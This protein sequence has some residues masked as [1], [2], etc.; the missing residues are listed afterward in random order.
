MK[1]ARRFNVARSRVLTDLP[2]AIIRG[3]STFVSLRQSESTLNLKRIVPC[4]RVTLTLGLSVALLFIIWTFWSDF[5]VGEI[6][7]SEFHFTQN[8]Y[9]Q[10]ETLDLSELGEN[11]ESS[12]SSSESDYSPVTTQEPSDQSSS[13]ASREKTKL[14]DLILASGWIGVIL[15]LGSIVAVSLIIKI[16]LTLR[17]SSFAPIQLEQALS[18]AIT[19]GT[20]EKALKLTESDDSFMARIVGAGLRE[21]DQ[22][23]NVVEKAVEDAIAR[24]TAVLYRKTEPLSLIG[25]VAPMLGLLGTVLGMV[26]TF[27]ELAVA[28]AGGRNLANGI[29]FAL[30]TTVDGLLVAI[31]IL[32]AHSLLNARI[33]AMVSEATRKIDDLFAPVKRRL[34]TVPSDLPKRM[35]A[36]QHDATVQGCTRNSAAVQV[37][38]L[39][40]VKTD[41]SQSSS[42][43][44]QPGSSRPSLSLKNRQ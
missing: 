3:V 14:I 42:S 11:N 6:A 5:A 21:T 25:N 7:R 9:A 35:S 33:A 2:F 22:E 31:P 39:R 17:R 10:D 43:S 1:G 24:E 29:Y 23:W 27:G 16:C 4:N 19:N 13:V 18:T 38:G 30:V 44:S 26:T 40:E 20:Y 37:S 41:E 12:A 15:L 28:D 36:V 34:R 8:V 32:V